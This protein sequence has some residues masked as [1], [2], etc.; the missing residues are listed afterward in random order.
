VLVD[1]IG[2]T[3]GNQGVWCAMNVVEP[4][5]VEPEVPTAQASP[6]GSADTPL[7]EV[8]GSDPLGLG[9]TD[10]AVPSQ[11]MASVAVTVFTP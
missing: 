11:C 7:T 10:Q 1:A 5:V 4:V 9:T 8:L 3:A 2:R 6:D